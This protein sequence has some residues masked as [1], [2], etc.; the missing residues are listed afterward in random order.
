[1]EELSKWILAICGI[2]VVSVV[3]ELLFDG[4]KMKKMIRYVC[5]IAVLLCVASPLASA[6]G[7][8][9][10]FKEITIEGE[11]IAD[12]SYLAYVEKLKWNNVELGVRKELQNKGFPSSEVTVTYEFNGEESTVLYVTV[13]FEKTGI[14]ESDE[15]INMNE[16]RRLVSEFVGVD[17]GRVIVNE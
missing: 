2:T 9:F 8:D 13:S 5:G 6:L 10:A 3:A 14:A 16:V 1:M 17:D 4:S 12:S 15:H 11:S 7:V